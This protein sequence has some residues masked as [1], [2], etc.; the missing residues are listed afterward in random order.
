MKKFLIFLIFLT[1]S[2]VFALG[3]TVRWYASI[4]PNVTGYNIYYGTSYDVLNQIQDVGNV[5]TYTFTDLAPGMWFFRAKAYNATG[6]E[7]G[8]SGGAFSEAVI[9]PPQAMRIP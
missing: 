3:L 8:F 5:L 7:S 6:Q 4:D 2:T 9:L 1:P